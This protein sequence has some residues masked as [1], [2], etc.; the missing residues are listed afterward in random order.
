MQPF[1]QIHHDKYKDILQVMDIPEWPLELLNARLKYLYKVKDRDTKLLAQLEIGPEQV[2]ALPERIAIVPRDFKGLNSLKPSEVNSRDR[3]AVLHKEIST[4]LQ[5]CIRQISQVET[6]RQRGNVTSE[7]TNSDDDTTA[8]D[9]QHN[10]NEREEQLIQKASRLGE[11]L[12]PGLN[13]SIDAKAFLNG[14]IEY[15]PEPYLILRD[16][17]A[18]TWENVMGITFDNLAAVI[19]ILARKYNYRIISTVCDHHTM[20]VFMEKMGSLR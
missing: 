6:I 17:P 10:Q 11:S 20:Y 1:C 12:D 19:N 16:S 18:V 14:K 9:L 5:N 8:Q 2:G 7:I 15:L 3:L 13:Y 4:N